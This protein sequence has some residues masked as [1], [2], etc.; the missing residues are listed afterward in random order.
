M[1]GR[2]DARA[3]VLLAC[4]Y[5]FTLFDAGSVRPALWTT[6]RV[7]RTLG[8]TVHGRW[9]TC[10][11]VHH[12]A[13]LRV[14]P[15]LHFYS[16]ADFPRPS[17]YRLRAVSPFGSRQRYAVRTRRTWRLSCWASLPPSALPAACTLLHL[18]LGMRVL[19][20][21]FAITFERPCSIRP[22]RFH[23]ILNR[24]LYPLV[25]HL[26][27]ARCRAAAC[28]APW[29]PSRGF[30]MV[31]PVRLR[32]FALYAQSLAPTSTSCACA[33]GVLLVA[34]CCADVVNMRRL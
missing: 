32:M 31:R 20:T 27:T 22:R 4:Y 16:F 23:G 25:S 19:P 34:I 30:T 29:V 6:L 17:A 12:R 26:W 9:F 5:N 13:R 10:L 8:G 24:C 1:L 21:T 28:H 2:F 7:L 15:P 18:Q 14:R 11:A 33:A 3:A